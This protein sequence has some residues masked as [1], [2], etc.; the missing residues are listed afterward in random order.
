MSIL[1]KIKWILGILLIF[2]LIIATN[3]IDKENFKQIKKSVVSIY[4]DRLLAKEII[5]EIS[6]LVNEKE[7]AIVASDSSFYLHENA[8]VNE[9]INQAIDRFEQTELTRQEKLEFDA[10]KRNLMLLQELEAKLMSNGFQL[11]ESAREEIK[12]IK[13]NLVDLSGIQ[14]EEG[15]K[16][17]L[18]S[19]RAVDSIELYTQLEIYFLILLAIILQVIILYNPK[20]AS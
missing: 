6:T 12:E 8:V 9:K 13:S 16:H 11:Q 14:I 20:K 5:F 18:L 10:L 2:A 15:K 3:L 19:E 4:E 7:M 1:N 17:L